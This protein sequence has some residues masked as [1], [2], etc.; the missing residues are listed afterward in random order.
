MEVKESELGIFYNQARLPM[1]GQGCICLS[2]WARG[3]R[4]DLP[5]TQADAR[6]KDC[7]PKTESWAPLPR[8]TS[9]PL[10]EQAGAWMEPSP[11]HSNCSAG[12]SAFSCTSWETS[13]FTSPPSHNHACTRK[14]LNKENVPRAQFQILGNSSPD[15]ASHLNSHLSALNHTWAQSQ[16]LGDMSS[17]FA[18]SL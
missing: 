7:S 4:G 9:R 8:T 11:V 17:P 6:T 12:S 14:P 18:Y 16:L 10:I 13:P 3:S 15:A 5:T 1:V 2:W